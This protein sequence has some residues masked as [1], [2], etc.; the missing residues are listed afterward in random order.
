[1]A[2]HYQST[3]ALE[4]HRSK[5]IIFLWMNLQPIQK[6]AH[7]TQPSRFFLKMNLFFVQAFLIRNVQGRACLFPDPGSTSSLS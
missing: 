4:L 6:F 3:V 5:I 7:N 2:Y 1:M